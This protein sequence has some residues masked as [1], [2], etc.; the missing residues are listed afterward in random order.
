MYKSPIEVIYGQ[1]M[2]T[3]DDDIFRAVCSYD[4]NVDRDE[5]IRA[6]KYDRDQYN[7]GYEDGKRDA[8]ADLVRCKDCI[9]N[10][11]AT[12]MFSSFCNP[13]YRPEYFCADGERKER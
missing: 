12:C 2:K 8:L 13:H 11:K 5:L 7:R 4:I 9:Y 3:M 1:T 6:L 10:E